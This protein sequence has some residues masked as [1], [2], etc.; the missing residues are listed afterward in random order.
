[1]TKEI[2]N[3]AVQPDNQERV[4]RPSITFWQRMQRSTTERRGVIQARLK[5]VDLNIFR[6]PLEIRGT[7]AGSDHETF[8]Y[9]RERAHLV[10]GDII[11]DLLSGKNTIPV[12]AAGT[13][14]KRGEY[15]SH[16][17]IS[18][19]YDLVAEF[20][21]RNRHDVQLLS[22]GL[23]I[24]TEALIAGTCAVEGLDEKNKNRHI[25]ISQRLI[26][27]YDWLIFRSPLIEIIRGMHATGEKDSAGPVAQFRVNAVLGLLDVPNFLLLA[28]TV[29][30]SYT[31]APIGGAE[32]AVHAASSCDNSSAYLS[33]DMRN[34]LTFVL[35][36]YPL[37][38]HAR[39]EQSLQEALTAMEKGASAVLDT[40]EKFSNG[41]FTGE[42]TKSAAYT[43]F[44][45]VLMSFGVV[46]DSNAFM[47]FSQL[48]LGSE[49][50]I[51][52]ELY[53]KWRDLGPILGL[54]SSLTP[55][56]RTST[57]GERGKGIP[58]QPNLLIL[59]NEQ[60]VQTSLFELDKPTTMIDLFAYMQAFFARSGIS[61]TEVKEAHAEM[62]ADH[63]VHVGDDREYGSLQDLYARLFVGVEQAFDAYFAVPQE[64]Q[65]T[66]NFA[67][68]SAFCF[69]Y[70]LFLVELVTPKQDG[71]EPTQGDAPSPD[72]PKQYTRKKIVGLLVRIFQ[73]EQ[74]AQVR[75]HMIGTVLQHIYVYWPKEDIAAL[76][77]EYLSTAF[78]DPEALIFREG[79][80][81]D[82]FFRLSTESRAFLYNPTQQR[83]ER[84]DI[85]QTNIE[86][87]LSIL[88]NLP[89]LLG[90]GA[91]QRVSLLATL[92]VG[93]SWEDHFSAD[94]A[95]FA[96]TGALASAAHAYQSAE[97]LPIA[98]QRDTAASV[99]QL[100]SQVFDIVI[101]LTGS[102]QE[103]QEKVSAEVAQILVRLTDS[104]IQTY[105][106]A[107][108]PID[109]VQLIEQEE[110]ATQQLILTQLSGKQ[111]LAEKITH[112]LPT[113]LDG[114]QNSQQQVLLLIEQITAQSTSAVL[115]AQLLES[116]QHMQE[117]LTER[118]GAGYLTAQN[119]EE[120]STSAMVLQHTQLRTNL[121][122]VASIAET[123]QR[124]L[125]SVHGRI[126][127]GMSAQLEQLF[128][129]LQ[130][131]TH[132]H[133]SSV[134]SDVRA[135][136]VTVQQ[137]EALQERTHKRVTEL[138]LLQ[139]EM[140]HH[141]NTTAV[142]LR[143]AQQQLLQQTLPV[144]I[145]QHVDLTDKN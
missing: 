52:K 5:T 89:L 71:Y 132:A 13:R 65:N 82:W 10:V 4:I 96:G 42:L 85:Q 122:Y 140:T 22:T 123:V 129:I 117:A 144:E 86:T 87:V 47:R 32:F 119:G 136:L 46:L 114:L 107:E 109:W 9:V 101:W 91:Q 18:A 34:L 28:N 63:G 19:L 111:G 131:V 15:Q 80:I 25:R 78:E 79:V 75:K 115:P 108:V 124:S 70:L 53:A 39:G 36:L 45:N 73:R 139:Q 12:D 72:W 90:T 126:D 141:R 14:N 81:F 66:K 103:L 54:P 142:S 61:L 35:R 118:T 99:K 17:S 2:K 145:F 135:F 57:L 41:L 62:Y 83:A 38:A 77:A 93:T 133:M 88:Q 3:A 106:P 98:A 92:S 33:Q 104:E 125:S 84:T 113:V 60:L 58:F 6:S 67:D 37:A 68:S 50:R 27:L 55:R 100:L 94:Q 116:L 137:Q 69:Y 23:E 49:G 56:M 102:D 44:L 26:A 143:L 134:S 97:S 76:N 120:P 127:E 59:A 40:Q 31:K 48:F 1:M 112:E 105:L 30:S 51:S 16:R 130:A 138:L 43:T 29:S 8:A 95:V 11:G 128:R 110:L 121:N 20:A 21:V 64:K 24:F 74:D 7:N